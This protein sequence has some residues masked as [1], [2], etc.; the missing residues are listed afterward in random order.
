MITVT[1]AGESRNYPTEATENWIN[2]QVNRRRKDGQSV[3]AQV[4]VKTSG[5]DLNLT[6]PGCGGGGGGGRAP[7]SNE[8]RVIELWR[9]R[10][11]TANDFTGGNLIA[12]LKQLQRLVG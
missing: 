4:L 5:L 11:L 1:I 3:C 12:F 8:E 2:D 7:N 9:D 6:T 10:H